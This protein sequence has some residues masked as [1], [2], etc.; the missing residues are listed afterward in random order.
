MV[1]IAFFTGNK[2]VNFDFNGQ[3]ITSDGA[4]LLLEKIERNSRILRNIA[5]LIP[6]DRQKGSIDYSIYDMLRQRVFL[7]MLDYEDC[8]DEKKTQRRSCYQYI[9]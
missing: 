3:N 5:N 2:Q 6:D 7:N 4:V 1:N 8:N 9:V